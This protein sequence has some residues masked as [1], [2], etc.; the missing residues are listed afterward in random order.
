MNPRLIPSLLVSV[1]A[2]LA[3]CKDLGTE[4]LSPMPHGAYAYS[5]LDSN[6]ATIVRGWFTMVFSDTGTLSG[7]WHFLPIGSRDDIGPQIGDGQLTG[8]VIDT[9]LYVNLNPKYVDRN[10]FLSGRLDTVFYHGT[11]VWDTFGGISN[12]GTFE[13]I[14]N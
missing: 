3:A 7:E 14:R 6:G 13:A 10:V 11:W 8:S 5:A 9:M 1:V 4:A 12:R 2:A